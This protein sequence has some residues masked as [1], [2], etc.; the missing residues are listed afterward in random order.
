MIEWSKNGERHTR[1]VFLVFEKGIFVQPFSFNVLK[2]E[3]SCG[4]A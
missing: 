3:K 4:L 1:I 2:D